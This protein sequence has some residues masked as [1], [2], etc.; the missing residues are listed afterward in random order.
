M[1]RTRRT[2]PVCGDVPGTRLRRQAERRRRAVML[3]WPR[4]LSPGELDAYGRGFGEGWEHGFTCGR[5]D[6]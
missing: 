3:R 4:E 2:C 6:D 5:D 1:S